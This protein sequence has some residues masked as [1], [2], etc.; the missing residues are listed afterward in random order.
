MSLSSFDEPD[1]DETTLLESSPERGRSPARIRNDPPLTSLLTRVRRA[2]CRASS[3]RRL[4]AFGLALT[5][6][7]T[8]I[9]VQQHRERRAALRSQAINRLAELGIDECRHLFPS[10][11]TT[12]T[13]TPSASSIDE[14]RDAIMQPTV[15]ASDVAIIAPSL[16]VLVINGHDGVANE[17]RYVLSMV[18]RLTNST[19]HV[20]LSVGLGSHDVPS[21]EADAWFAAH[22]EHC[23]GKYDAIIVGDTIALSRPYLQARCATAMVLYVSNRY[24]YALHDDAA[25]QQL[26]AEAST[27]PHVRVTQNNL[28]EQWYATRFRAAN[29]HVFDYITA[30]GGISPVQCDIYADAD[31]AM[32][33]AND[34]TVYILNKLHAPHLLIQPLQALGIELPVLPGHYGGQIALAN[35][36]IVHSPYQANTMTLFE[37]L[38]VNVTFLLPSLAL[39]RGWMDAGR[40]T[41]GDKTDSSFLTAADLSVDDMMS[42]VDWYR[43]ELAHLF[44]Y[45]ESLED[46]RPGSAFRERVASQVQQHRMHIAEFM[47]QHLQNVSVQWVGILAAAVRGARQHGSQQSGQRARRTVAR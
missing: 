16:N 22:R 28:A 41:I 25:F 36:I 34:S 31:E 29:L 35:R 18:G 14:Q 8:L 20:E 4:F 42:V 11:L 13:S 10:P 40:A 47:Q 3:W 38:R 9:T 46:L 43:P 23:Q 21:G 2:C 24:D 30:S 45:F 32:P 15:L 5:L 17:L 7:A 39:F 27:W 19:V 12:S 6:V 26:F 37:A 33:Q 44:Y 1:A